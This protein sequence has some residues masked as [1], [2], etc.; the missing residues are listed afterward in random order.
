MFYRGV[1]AMYNDIKGKIALVTGAAQGIGLGTAKQLLENGAIVYL[2]DIDIS[3]LGDSLS[4]YYNDKAIP[5]FLDVTDPSSWSSIHDIIR[6]DRGRLDILVN[7]AGISPAGS[8]ESTSFELWKKVQNINLDSVFLGCN[9][10]FPLLKNSKMSS[11]INLSSI[12]GIKS[13][14]NLAAYSASKGAVRLLTKSIALHGAQYN[15]RC[16]SVHPGG[17]RTRMLD[18]FIKTFES[19]EEALKT[20]TVGVPMGV[21]GEISDI[22][23]MILFLASDVSKWITGS[24]M[25]VDGGTTLV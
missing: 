21:V 25:L 3:A 11:I 19:E 12:M 4:S 17:I 2:A 18:D 6:K 20:Y 22:S 7:N 24:E 15:I 5:V 8:V 10:L 1:D 23:N 16:N 13:D 14:P 9:L